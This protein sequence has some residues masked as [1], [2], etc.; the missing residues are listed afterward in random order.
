ML[1]PQDTEIVKTEAACDINGILF[2]NDAVGY[3]IGGEKYDSSLFM[4]TNDG[5]KTWIRFKDTAE[6]PKGVY[7]IAFDG[8]RVIAGGFEG[9]AY[10]AEGNPAEWVM[11]RMPEWDWIQNM[12]FAAPNKGF[13]VTGEGYAV[14]RI[15]KFDAA[16]NAHLVDSFDYQLSDIAFANEQIG[17]ACGYGAVLKT[18][19]GE[20][21]WQLQDIQ[22]DFYKSISIV[23]A[24]NVWAVGYN[25]SIIHTSDGGKHWEKQRNGDNPLISKYRFRDVVFK[26]TSTGYAVGDKGIMLKTTDAGIHWSLFKEVTDKDLKCITI[27]TDGSLWIGGSDG[28]VLHITE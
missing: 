1:Y 22:G 21:S 4:S 8:K 17:Y 3:I 27:K 9:R 6:H 15:Y 23:D 13:L 16:F 7:G 14:G 2:I 28:F 25:G 20:N 5:G 18:L 10:L 12:T 24:E 26:N 19:D 11:R